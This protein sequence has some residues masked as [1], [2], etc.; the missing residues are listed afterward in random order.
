MVQCVQGAP[1]ERAP[2]SGSDPDLIL[3][4]LFFYKILIP[5]HVKIRVWIWRVSIT[6]NEMY[7]LMA[8][9]VNFIGP[10]RRVKFVFKKKV[11]IIKKGL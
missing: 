11:F 9:Q 10:W 3:L 7:S 5:K 8:L 6:E 1:G 4:I 2:C